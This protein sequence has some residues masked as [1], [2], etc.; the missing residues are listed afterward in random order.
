MNK[1]PHD[2][3]GAY[4]KNREDK[5]LSDSAIQV[6]KFGFTILN[7]GFTN[8]EISILSS[9]FDDLKKDY[10]KKYSK[11]IIIRARE[12]NIIRM[13]L[14]FKKIFLDL[15]F[16]KPLINLIA[17]LIE[18][19]F[20]L[21]QQNGLTNMPNQNYSQAKWHRDLPY[22]HFTTSKPIAISGLFCID[23]FTSHNGA[24]FILPKSHQNEWIPKEY[25][26]K[27]SA[28]QIEASRGQFIVMDSMAFHSGGINYSS[29]K[30]RAINHVFTIPFFKHQVNVHTALKKYNLSD[31]QKQVLG[32]KN[33]V[34]NSLEEFFLSK[35]KN[36]SDE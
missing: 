30:R 1:I 36:S 23:D 29:E 34:P 18:G 5:K 26:I 21:N 10:S 14:A 27:R 8:K 4:S 33:L 9:E 17:E 19:E 31:F 25:D 22:Q 20:L 16:N 32:F 6:R 12:D 28:T 35:I 13:P 3:Y 11:D 2:S 15:A 24:T 7:S